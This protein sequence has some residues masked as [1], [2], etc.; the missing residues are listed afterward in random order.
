M[1]VG[2]LVGD[3]DESYVGREVGVDEMSGEAVGFAHAAAHG[4]AVHGMAQALFGHTYEKFRAG[5]VTFVVETPD[6]EPG[7]GHNAVV[8][9]FATHSRREQH[10]DCS[11]TAEFFFFV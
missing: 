8:P 5:G 1:V 11:D 7:V 2:E 9:A 10:I 4:D 6:V 3:V